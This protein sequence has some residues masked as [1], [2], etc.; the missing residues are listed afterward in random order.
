MTAMDGDAALGSNIRR[1][2]GG[3]HPIVAV[4]SVGLDGL[5]LATTGTTTTAD[6]EIGSISKALTGLLYADACSRGE[7][8]P[9]TTLGTLLPLPDKEIGAITLGSLST[10]RSGL[11]RL[12]A[13]MNPLRRTVQMWTHGASP[14][15]ETLEE[16]L[17]QVRSTKLRSPKVRY[18]NLGFQLLGHAVAQAAGQ[19]FQ[20]LLGDRLTRPLGLEN[21]YAPYTPAELTSDA[22][23]GRSRFGRVQQPWTG[24][25][26]APAG[27]VRASI[28]D[29]GRLVCALL[30]ESSPG[31][32]ALDPVAK[33]MGPARIGAGWMTLDVKGRKIT[34]H[35]GATGGFASWIG[36]DRAAGTGLVILS[37]TAA[38]V[39]KHG[40]A[41]LRELTDDSP[42][43]PD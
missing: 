5:S 24:E 42:R 38:S 40:F 1:R 34:W 7:V 30:D 21:T 43:R 13:G 25:A 28:A 18:S 14:Y 3:R 32:A 4:A 9:E 29:M 22:V 8:T 11:P 23:V 26:I 37:A 33:L 10:H 17:A 6:L 41:L 35:N 19:S 2:L 27:G 12:P 31:M 39:D 16:L 15:G 20:T 36:V